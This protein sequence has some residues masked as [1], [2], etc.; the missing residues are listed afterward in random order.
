MKKIDKR[1]TKYVV[2]DTETANSIDCPLVYDVGFE[3]IDSK[4]RVYEKL[5]ALF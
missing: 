3:V 4:G 5:G 2:L 1:V